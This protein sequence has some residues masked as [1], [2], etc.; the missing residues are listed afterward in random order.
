MTSM[1]EA[2]NQVLGLS[3]DLKTEVVDMDHRNH[4]PEMMNMEMTGSAAGCLGN[5]K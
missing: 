4:S 5:Q 3:V 1:W 2:D